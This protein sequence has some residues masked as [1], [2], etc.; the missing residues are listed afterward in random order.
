MKKGFALLGGSLVLAALVA[1]SPMA[2]AADPSSGTAVSLYEQAHIGKIAGSG[3]AGEENGEALSATF[4]YPMG[5][6][7]LPN[8][9]VYVAD[10]R[11]QLIRH[12]VSDTVDTYAGIIVSNDEKGFPAGTW[13]D[14]PL[15]L[16]LF[17]YPQGMAVDAQGIL[18]V[19]DSGNH[20]IRKITP[21]EVVTIAGDG[22][23]GHQDGAGGQARFYSP[24]DVAVAPDGT[25]YVA[26]TLN[27]AIRKI[28]PD[29]TVTTLNQVSDR[30]AR[31][32]SDYVEQAGDY[33]D[34]A[35]AEA[36]FNEPSGLA[37]DERGNL[38]V[39]DTGNQRIRYID[40][41]SGTVTT[42]AGNAMPGPADDSLY[43]EGGY[44]DGEAAS[45]QFQF[46]RGIAL[47]AE[48]GLVIADSQNQ[49]VRYLFNGRVTTL[50]GGDSSDSEK[51]SLSLPVD[52]AVDP[53]G[54]IWVVDS[55]ANAILHITPGTAGE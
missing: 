21:E 52:V 7:L 40:L 30:V 23:L 18:Y 54:T 16:S 27:H 8:G 46:P 51:P 53:Q 29:G 33:R 45:A 9:T 38:Y 44:T 35:L 26:D 22:V 6:A 32:H 4:R 13:I 11:N 41:Q 28:A 34:G 55:F 31:L 24:A 19:A 49:S 10:T 48:G 1:G 2:Q 25:V 37:L 15:K 5:I 36:L 47:T 42:V 17:Q 12:I 43:A 50:A 20:A 14:G 39:S 3:A